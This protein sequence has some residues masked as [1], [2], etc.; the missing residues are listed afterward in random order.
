MTGVIEGAKQKARVQRTAGDEMQASHVS[1]PA[2]VVP[3]ATEWIIEE[4][5][6]IVPDAG[7]RAGAN[8][9]L[10][11][12]AILDVI[13]VTKRK[14]VFVID[15]WDAPYRLAADD[16]TSHE[17]YAGWLRSLFNDITF[18]PVAVAGAYLTGILPT[19]KHDHR[20]AVS[21]LREYTMLDP[22]A[23]APY[24]GF[25]ENEV[26]E[27]SSEARLDLQEMR[28]LYEGYTLRYVDGEEDNRCK[29]VT[30]TIDSSYSVIQAVE[31]CEVGP[32][33]TTTESFEGLR[34]YVDIDLDGLKEKVVRVLSGQDVPIDSSIQLFRAVLIA[35]AVAVV[36]ALVVTGN[37]TLDNADATLRT[38]L[39]SA[40]ANL[41]HAVDVALSQKATTYAP[42]ILEGTGTDG[43]LSDLVATNAALNRVD[44]GMTESGV[45]EVAIADAN[46]IIR[47]S[48]NNKALNFDLKADD[49]TSTFLEAFETGVTHVEGLEAMP[50]DEG[51]EMKYVAVPAD[52][53]LL[54]VG[55]GKDAYE[56][57][58][59]RQIPA[60]TRH[61]PVGHADSI[62]VVTRDGT[63]VSAPEQFFD[64]EVAAEIPASVAGTPELES[65]GSDLYGEDS[66]AMYAGYH[67]Y[68]FLALYP[69]S[70][71]RFLRD[72]ITLDIAL[73]MTIVF[74]ALFFVRTNDDRIIV[75]RIQALGATL[76]S[77]TDGDLTARAEV[78]GIAEF[79]EL[80]DDINKTVDSLE[81]LIE[82]AKNQYAKDLETART[83]Q[84]SALPSVFPPY[85]MRQEFSLF[86]SMDAAREVGGDFYDYFFIDAHRLAILVADVSDKG[87]PASLFMMT[88]KTLIHNL[89]RTGR[90]VEEVA[91]EANDELCQNNEADMFVT[92][93]LGILD[94]RCGHMDFVNAGHT[95]PC[96]CRVTGEG[97]GRFS[98][99]EQRRN[100]F[101]GGVEGTIYRRQE[102]DLAPG[103]TIFLYSDGVT[104]ATDS[105]EDV[106]GGDR[107]LSSLD[108][109]AS[110][111]VEE[112]CRGVKQDV[113]DF[114]GE[115]EQFDDIT[116]LAL[117]FHQLEESYAAREVK[118]VV[119]ELS[120]PTTEDAV[121]EVMRFVEKTLKRAGCDE[122]LIDKCCLV[123]DEIVSNVVYYAYD[124]EVGWLSLRLETEKRGSWVRLSFSDSGKAFNPLVNPE[125]DVSLALDA[126]PIGGL[127]IFLTKTFCDELSY[128]RVD[129]LNVL[130]VTIGS[131]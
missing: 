113:L 42:I 63:L 59:G 66:E 2:L 34:S 85:P 22:G 26:L 107:L 75:Q 77:I 44:A 33:W 47:E 96:V 46:G 68:F 41:D 122:E 51:V 101:L 92:M 61:V 81:S 21:G 93:W 49:R 4:L 12:N 24:M 114:T 90:S 79:S 120:I 100:L 78:R 48:S 6:K 17:T 118:R 23:Y 99:I 19:S 35:F 91:A 64:E 127:G 31:R 124:G 15:E 86:A 20:T 53:C 55:F 80:S 116:M 125:P 89:A 112:I 87:I 126:R 73:M 36:S 18:T 9:V 69:R 29:P 130:S 62:V 30:V 16:V 94:L 109:R 3:T 25:T 13:N 7:V 43:G 45:A 131:T 84:R 37:F 5:H 95:V 98:F 117:T 105:S 28:H 82:E 111:S 1:W 11:T 74:S 65:G 88:A 70:E 72:I 38:S 54:L 129:D 10:L 102:I 32:Y 104:E 27:L 119:N 106:F 39:K 52:G 83:I 71:L 108:Q 67:D 97:S 115:A 60:T 110:L 50:W 57:E 8:D 14:F 123:V 56:E 128:D 58:V 103:D 40:M 121:D 76:G